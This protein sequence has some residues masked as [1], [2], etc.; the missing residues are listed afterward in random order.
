MADGIDFPPRQVPFPDLDYGGMEMGGAPHSSQ[1]NGHPY[2]LID[3]VPV[4]SFNPPL[5]DSHARGGATHYSGPRVKGGYPEIDRGFYY[6]V[7]NSE[8]ITQS[9]W[10][11]NSDYYFQTLVKS[12]EVSIWGYADEGNYNFKVLVD[13]EKSRLDIWDKPRDNYI[14]I[15]TSDFPENSDPESLVVSLREIDICEEDGNG[16]PKKMLVLCSQPYTTT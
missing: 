16:N 5:T 11:V 13:A 15:D 2:D 10:G 4:T 1:I 8:V 3:D 12:T 14:I 7:D 6:T 9:F